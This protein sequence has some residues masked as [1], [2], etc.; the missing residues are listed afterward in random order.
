MKWDEPKAITMALPIHLPVPKFM[1]YHLQKWK[2][3]KLVSVLACKKEN[4]PLLK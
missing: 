2:L 4:R 3:I 1:A